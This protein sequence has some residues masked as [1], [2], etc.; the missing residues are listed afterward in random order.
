MR[1][2]KRVVKTKNYNFVIFSHI[3]LNLSD[4]QQKILV[5]VRIAIALALNKL[6]FF[7]FL[8]RAIAH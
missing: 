6:A 8:L 1:N 7:D 2:R 3:K 5:V 4:T